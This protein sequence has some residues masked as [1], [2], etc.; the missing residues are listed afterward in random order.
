MSLLSGRK[1]TPQP[2]LPQ[3]IP[4]RSDQV[5]LKGARDGGAVRPIEFQYVPTDL[6]E[7]GWEG[8]WATTATMNQDQ[9]IQQYSNGKEKGWKFTM[10]LWAED[11]SQDIQEMY[12][13]MK[14]CVVK[15]IGLARPA[16]FVFLW[17]QAIHSTV[18]IKSLGDPRWDS[19]RDDGSLRGVTMGIVLAVYDPVNYGLTGQADPHTYYYTIR[20]GDTWEGIA[21]AEYGDPMLGCLL[22]QDNPTMPHPGLEPGTIVPLAP[23]QTISKRDI[24]IQSRPL[25]RTPAGLAL[26]ARMFQ[27]RSAPRKSMIV[28]A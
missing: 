19:L 5:R 4:V 13:L 3:L 11:S 22:R 26:R 1:F 16:R 17:G 20:Y 24:D 9:P 12:E 28:S 23:Y 2:P 10:K 21:L 15:D 7:T 8:E 6:Q 18:V 14:R 25:M 27:L